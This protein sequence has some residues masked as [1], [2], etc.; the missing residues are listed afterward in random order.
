MQTKKNFVRF[1]LLLNA[2]YLMKYATTIT[3][4]VISKIRLGNVIGRHFAFVFVA[5]LTG[6]R[7]RL[8]HVLHHVSRYHTTLTNQFSPRR[9]DLDLANNLE[10]VLLLVGIALLAVEMPDGASGFESGL[11]EQQVPSAAS[12]AVVIVAKQLARQRPGTG[13]GA[14][15]TWKTAPGGW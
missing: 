5:Y 13:P 6:S 10:I 2:I 4:H 1:V 9:F 7:F 14:G 15:C 11:G 3:I 8:Y 12:H